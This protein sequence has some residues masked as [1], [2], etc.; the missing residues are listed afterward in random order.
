MIF[1]RRT[2]LAAIGL[3]LPAAAEA[4]TPTTQHPRR[5]KPHGT[6]LARTATKP[7]KPRAH[8]PVPTQS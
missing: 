7:H 4:A 3:A 8:P 1:N 2:F 6:H 5:R